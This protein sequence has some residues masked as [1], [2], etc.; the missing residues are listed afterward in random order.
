MGSPPQPPS[1]VSSPGPSGR[2]QWSTLLLREWAAR[3]FPGVPLQEQYRLGPTKLN[4]VGVTVTPAL[5][6]MMRV[7]NWFADAIMFTPAETMIV[8][9]KVRPTP[10]AVSQVQFYADLLP[11]TPGMFE[12]L[13]LPI[14]CVLLFA[15]DD[16]RVTN[17]ARRHGCAVYIY[18]PSWIADYLAGVQYRGILKAPSEGPTSSDGDGTT[19]AS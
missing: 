11:S 19:S 18:T 8:E 6:A 7:N 17:F 15:E 9:A 16:P 13:S 12:R 2:R 5:E 10:S 1:P 4:L 14:R 3:T